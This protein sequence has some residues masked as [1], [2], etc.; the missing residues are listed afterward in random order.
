[1]SF[2]TQHQLDRLLR[3]KDQRARKALRKVWLEANH[4]EVM[5][6]MPKPKP[7]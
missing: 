5:A 1:M 2:L 3:I 6:M 4:R 7:K